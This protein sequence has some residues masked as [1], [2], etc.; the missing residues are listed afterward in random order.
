MRLG[1]VFGVDI[2]LNPFFLALL[3]LFF[4]AGVLD[5]GLVA[6]GVVLV[7]EMAHALVARHLGITA[8]EVELLPFG[9]VARAGTE[10]QVDPL[11]ETYTALAGPASNLAMITLAVALKNYG[12]WHSDLGPF[13]LQCNLLMAAFNLL[14]ALP[15]DGGRILR[16]YL[17]SR[18]GITPATYR[19]ALLGQAFAVL[20]V[21]VSVPGI[22]WGACGLD[23]PVTA[24]F[25]FYAA[26]RERSA[27]PY[28]FVQLLMR[29]QQELRREGVLPVKQLVAMENIPLGQLIQPFLPRRFHLVTVLDRRWHYMGTINELTIIDALLNRGADVPVGELVKK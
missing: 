13:F 11:R 8:N 24:F 20:I 4:V 26:T 1:R 18:I 22:W 17:A 6:F 29:K 28:L 21:L 5:R 9:G 16:S 23:I 10:L 27:A 15:L 25:L 19:T 14:P 12:L 7:H 2:Y 3:A